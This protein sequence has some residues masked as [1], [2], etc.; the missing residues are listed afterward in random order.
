MDLVSTSIEAS[1]PPF[2]FVT[3]FLYLVPC[4]GY[5]RLLALSQ[6][7]AFLVGLVYCTFPINLLTYAWNDYGDQAVDAFNPRKGQLLF[8]TKGVANQT[9]ARLILVA[10]LLQVPFG[11]YFAS[12]IGWIDTLYYGAVVILSNYLYN[13]W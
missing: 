13:T 3:V 9:L 8:G 7:R 12:I 1:R 10:L 11:M 2:W 5:D 4:G 6:T